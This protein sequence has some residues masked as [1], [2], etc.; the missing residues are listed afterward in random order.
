VRE[1]DGIH[2]NVAGTEI[3]ARVVARALRGR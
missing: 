2:L 3:A 1:P